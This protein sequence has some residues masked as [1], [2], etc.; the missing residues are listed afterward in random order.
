MS[1][2]EHV[3]LSKVDRQESHLQNISP[4]LKLTRQTLLL[5]ICPEPLKPVSL[6]Q[7]LSVRRPP[8]TST[9]SIQSC[10]TTIISQSPRPT[11]S[12]RMSRV[13]RTPLSKEQV[14]T[15]RRLG[16]TRKRQ[17]AVAMFSWSVPSRLL[18]QP[19]QQSNPTPKTVH[20]L[21]RSPKARAVYIIILCTSRA[22]HP[23]FSLLA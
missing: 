6:T 2:L 8:I 21:H 11:Q 5:A 14:G 4:R 18:P 7:V 20:C 13:E 16:E 22:S 23:A 3:N 19:A 1:Q 10:G 15:C 9:S 17:R 12:I